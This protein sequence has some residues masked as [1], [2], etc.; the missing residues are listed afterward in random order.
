MSVSFQ[1]IRKE[2]AVKM[3]RLHIQVIQ[4]QLEHIEKQTGENVW[5]PW[6][7]LHFDSELNAV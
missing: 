3:L 6:E 4:G 5:V 2:E 7:H 1:K